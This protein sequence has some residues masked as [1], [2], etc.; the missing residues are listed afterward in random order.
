LERHPDWLVR[1]DDGRPISAGHMWDQ[2]LAVLDVTHPGA[3]EHLLG[4]FRAF[5]A[6][7]VSHF[8]LDYCYAG[9]LPGRRHEDVDPI[10]AYR[11]GLELV[12]EAA[13]P[14]ATIHGCGAPLLPSI[15]LVDIMRVS[16]D[17]A[18]TLHPRSGDISQPSQLGA[19]LTGAAREFL[20][21]RWWANDPDCLIVRPAVEA[22]EQWAAHIESSGGVRGASDPMASL[23]DWG[24]QTTRRLLTPSQPHPTPPPATSAPA[25]AGGWE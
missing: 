5:T 6:L 24:V 18:P 15:G 19:R 7:G 10:T 14:Q 20:H 25:P 13:G 21:A 17:M 11:R 9:A 23:D 4:V 1:G 22:R 16:P 2:R 3:A 8:K 12:R